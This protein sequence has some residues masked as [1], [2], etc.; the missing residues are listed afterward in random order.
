MSATKQP[1]LLSS[2]RTSIQRQPVRVGPHRVVDPD[3][4]GVEPAPA[5]LEEV[6]QQEA[7]SRSGPAGTPAARTGPA[8]RP[9]A[10]ARGWA[11]GTNLFQALG[12]VPPSV[13]DRAEQR[14]DQE[15]GPRHLPAAQVAGRGRPPGVAGEPRARRRRRP[16]PPRR[17]RLASMPDSAAANSKVKL[18]VQLRP[19]PA[20]NAS[21]VAGRSGRHSRQV[22]LPV[23]PPADEP[24]VVAAGADQ[25]AGDGQVDRG[26][27][28]RLR[29]QPVVGVGGGVGQP[30]VQHDH[31]GPV[32]AR[33]S[34][35]RWACGLK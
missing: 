35:M 24:G 14:G 20:S 18:G 27:A 33:A 22:L 2:V 28:A 15:Q 25:V 19:G 26:L 32:L 30:G 11:A 1:T 29:G 6:R 17:A 5:V 23:P 8:T 7:T 13:A 16:R 3:E 12:K 31:L 9:G 4:V 21:K 34:V 10:A